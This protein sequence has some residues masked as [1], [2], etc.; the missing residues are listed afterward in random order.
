MGMATTLTA[1]GPSAVVG[2]IVNLNH[3]PHYIHWG[4]FQISIANFVVIV[5]MV[6]VFVLAIAL[7]FSRKSRP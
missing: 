2:A 4:W 7:P 3:P 1:T 6:A 5:L